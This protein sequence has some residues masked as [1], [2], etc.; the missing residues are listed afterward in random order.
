MKRYKPHE[1]QK[2]FH[3]SKA[4][5]RTFIAGRRGGK[6]LAG[7][8]EALRQADR[9]PIKKKRPVHGMIIAP[10]Y[11]M[12]K[13]VNISMMM[14]WCPEYAIESWNK[15]DMRLE[16]VNGSSIT[17]RSGDNP[18]RLRGTEKDW[19][20]LDEACFMSKRVW[21]TVY[22]VLTSTEG[23]AWVTTTPQGYDWVY[24][25]FYKP[26][27]TDDNFAAW[28]FS[29]L[30]NPHINKELVEQA[31]KD[32]SE[33]MFRQEYMASFEKFEGLI[34]PDFS[35]ERHLRTTPN[36]ITDI[37]FVGLDVGWNHP[38]AGLLIKED[39]ERNVFVLDEFREQ[40]LT[41]DMI[42][43]QIKSMLVRNDLNEDKVEMFIIDPASKGT[44]QSSGQ[45][46]MD[47]LRQEGWGFMPGNNDVIA[48]INRATRL[49]RDDRLFIHPSRCPKLVDELNNYHWKKWDE[50]KDGYRNRPFKLQ[51]DLVDALRYIIMTRPDYFEHPRIDIYGRKVEEGADPITGYKPPTA[52]IFTNDSEELDVLM[53]DDGIDDLM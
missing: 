8:I 12:L 43:N 41:A 32:L 9:L 40:H 51:D 26:A 27:K 14:E 45:S 11:G 20:W 16:L 42:S 53:A 17:F 18:D 44:Q 15:V 2:K 7:T 47:Q 19:I 31:K 25:T 24:D 46:M 4:R 38:T 3:N 10:T 13:D 23:V 1:Y 28:R 33:V 49:F 39:R 37:F 5:F 52:G 22:P 50:E 6:S 48:G 30:K 21:E 34:Y 29:T 36:S 35:E